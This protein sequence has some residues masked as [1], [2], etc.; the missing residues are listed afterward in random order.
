MASLSTPPFQF[1]YL[2]RSRYSR[3][4]AASRWNW[5]KSGNERAQIVIQSR[6]LSAHLRMGLA[7][8]PRVTNHVSV[9]DGRSRVTPCIVL[10]SRSPGN[11]RR[12]VRRNVVP[13]IG[14][15]SCTRILPL[16]YL[17]QG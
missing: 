13:Q 9:E 11:P 6:R 12:G 15:F 1:L 8:P 2:A 5:G 7:D 3:R 4:S 17:D 16:M 10:F 14:R